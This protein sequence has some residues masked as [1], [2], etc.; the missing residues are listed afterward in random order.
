MEVNRENLPD[1]IN[2][3]TGDPRTK[4][5]I[6][7]RLNFFDKPIDS[8][9]LLG[10]IM[11]AFTCFL[12]N[13]VNPL[14]SIIVITGFLPLTLRPE[15]LVGPILLMTVFDD[16]LIAFRGQSFSRI[17]TVMF[18]IGVFVR[19]LNK[20]NTIKHQIYAFSVFMIAFMG[21]VLSYYSIF[22]YTSFP[23]SYVTNLV[24][25]F[26]LMN[27]VPSDNEKICRH[28]YIYSV[29]SVLYTGYMFMKNGFGALA[30][31][32]RI[33]IDAEVNPNQIAMGL[34]VVIVLLYCYF[35]AG[36]FKY[37]VRNLI[38][39]GL[40]CIGLFMTGSRTGFLAGLLSIIFMFFF[41]QKTDKKKIRNAII[42]A[43][44]GAVLLISVYS[45]LQAKFPVLMNRFTIKSV[46]STG[47]TS[48]I[49]IWTAY[50]KHYFPTYWFFGIGFD[51]LNMYYAV[52]LINGVGH[53]AH[54]VLVEIL[55]KSGVFGLIIYTIFFIGFFKK[56][57]KNYK[58]NKCQLLTLGIVLTSL[59]NGIGE[60]I[61]TGRFLWFGV[62]LGFLLMNTSSIYSDMKSHVPKNAV[63]ELK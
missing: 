20:R 52:K 38:L 28:L 5:N 48:R 45:F 1:I 56:V 10:I 63:N 32:Q 43:L 16:Y 35:A 41:M 39:I 9:L 44:F 25:A 47:G 30:E 51:P 17:C 12:G 37:K 18:I 46:V 24:L 53:G 49:D 54:N 14:L 36:G 34:A 2:L 23:I 8:Y 6:A 31:G 21:I 33:S 58:T 22:S 15:Y 29:I 4:K 40:T 57:L 27:C 59:I 19:M 55:S 26:F 11:S 3:N 60:D 13:R 61:I 62:G 42:I 7:S 50:L